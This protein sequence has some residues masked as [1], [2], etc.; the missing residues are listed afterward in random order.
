MSKTN[1]GTPPSGRLTPYEWQRAILASDLPSTTKLVLMALST[2]INKETG[3]AFPS[4]RTLMKE[5]SL[6]SEAVVKHIGDAKKAGW[7]EIGNHGYQDQRWARKSYRPRIPVNLKE[8]VSPSKTPYDIKGVSIE[9][10]GVSIEPPFQEAENA[11]E[12]SPAVAY[13]DPPAAPNNILTREKQERERE[14]E[15]PPSTPPDSLSVSLNSSQRETT[16]TAGEN[17]E[18]PEAERKP[19]PND[20]IPANGK[21]TTGRERQHQGNGAAQPLPV[22][23][24]L[25]DDDIKAAVQETR[26]TEA[27]IKRVSGKFRDHHRSKGTL[28]HDWQAEWHLWLQREIEYVR[29]NGK[30]ERTAP[31]PPVFV[32]EPKAP[33]DHSKPRQSHMAEIRAAMARGAR[34]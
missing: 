14:G 22:P 15:I 9:R 4:I 30:V 26:W 13:S 18:A 23:W 19:C 20:P 3:L 6:G 27:E 11:P 5:T 31:R 24:A 28:S 1:S 29:A 17:P 33:V 32:A 12:A 25:S 2:H 7:I 16:Q 10:E 8:G 21:P 34:S